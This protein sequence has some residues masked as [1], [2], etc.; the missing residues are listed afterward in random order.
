[1]TSRRGAPGPS[2]SARGGAA[3]TGRRSWVVGW[4]L[5]ALLAGLLV[6]ALLPRSARAAAG[7]CA[8]ST[9][10][11]QSGTPYALTLR[12]QGSTVISNV[13]FDGRVWRAAGG[14]VATNGLATPGATALVGAVRMVNHAQA[15]FSSPAAFAALL[16]LMKA[17]GCSGA[18][19]ARAGSA[20]A[21]G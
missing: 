16:P 17:D 14:R 11:A 20:L 5:A 2:R 6:F 19:V 8:G 3:A 21:R 9:G 7:Q 13:D 1:M 12:L 15:T 4:A 18:P 10:P